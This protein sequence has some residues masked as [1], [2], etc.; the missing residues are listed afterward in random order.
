MTGADEPG[1]T[2]PDTTGLGGSPASPPADGGTT[3]VPEVLA[4]PDDVAGTTAPPTAG[5]VVRPAR[6]RRGRA[7]LMA[8]AV[9]AVAATGTAVAAVLTGPRVEVADGAAPELRIGTPVLSAR[10]IPGWTSRPVAA[11]NLQADLDPVIARAPASTC[12]RIDDAGTTVAARAPEASLVPAS[13]MKL[14]TSAA[15]LDLLGAETRLNTRIAA[16]A[17]PAP[18][19]TVAGDL[20]VVGGGDPVLTTDTYRGPVDPAAPPPAETDLEGVADRIVAAGVRRVTGSVVGD[21]SRYDDVR[22]GPGWPPRFVENGTVAGLGALLVNDARTVDPVDPAGPPGQAAPDPAGHAADVMTRLL[23]ARG[24]VVDGPPRSGVAPAT[25]VTVLDVPSPT[26]RELV[27]ETATFSDNTSAELLL[28][29][30]GRTSGGGGSTAAGAAA[31]DAWLRA[32]GLPVEGV[33][34]AD[35][36]GLSP[37][38]RLTC[39]LLVRILQRD[40]TDGPLA[41]ALARPGRPGTLDDR[42]LAPDLRDRVRAKTGTLNEVT[43]LAGWTTGADQ[44]P[45]AFAVI[46]NTGDRQVEAQDLAVQEDL[47]RVLTTYPRTPGLDQIVPRPPVDG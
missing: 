39:T 34:V 37:L 8:A 41:A 18:D 43:S 40:G 7:W 17:A 10:R 30:I 24:V 22:T 38:N 33:T 35:G 11:R 32:E 27:V 44:R 13:N 4:V 46:E 12:V 14:V 23:Q 26:I 45:L 29:E 47:L 19:G 25:A 31:V 36:S 6:R 3:D 42:L 9:L 21:G 28:K 15:A 20:F 16:S 2:G 1:P 5:P